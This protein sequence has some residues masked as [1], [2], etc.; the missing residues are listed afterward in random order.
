M[1]PDLDPPTADPGGGPSHVYPGVEGFASCVRRFGEQRPALR[2]AQHSRGTSAT[3]SATE[4]GNVARRTRTPRKGTYH[5]TLTATNGAGLQA[6]TPFTVNVAD[7]PLIATGRTIVA[8]NPV[9][10]TVAS[11]IDT[12]PTNTPGRLQ[13][14]SERLLRDDPVG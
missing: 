12:D 11:F 4:T 1:L 6:S 3:A 9:S 14:G 5:G 13:P 10:A 7:A 2:S 8:P